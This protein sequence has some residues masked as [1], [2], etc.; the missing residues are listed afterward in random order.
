M[1]ATACCSIQPLPR[2]QSLAMSLRVRAGPQVQLRAPPRSF[3]PAPAAAR[4][5]G[6]PSRPGRQ[7][8]QLARLA[9]AARA[10]GWPP[11]DTCTLHPRAETGP[12]PSLQPGQRAAARHTH[13][14]STQSTTRFASHVQ[15]IGTLETLFMMHAITSPALV[16]GVRRA[17]STMMAVTPSSSSHCAAA[18]PQG[19][20]TLGRCAPKLPSRQSA[21]GVPADPADDASRLPHVADLLVP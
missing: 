16:A 17:C 3:G 10:A 19:G 21:R 1:P 5:G 12:H 9:A 20:G 11:A 14:T 18:A 8:L 15:G 2:Q 4:P 7:R 13:A 6:A